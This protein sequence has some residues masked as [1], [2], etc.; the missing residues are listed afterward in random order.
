VTNHNKAFLE[1]RQI[2][3]GKT[4]ILV[5]TPLI[6]FGII[7]CES[8][9]EAADIRYVTSTS[10]AI[11]FLRENGSCRQVLLDMTFGE[12]KILNLGREL[13]LINPSIGILIISKEDP[14]TDMDEIQP[15]KFL[16]KPLL[17][18]DI[19]AA[20]GLEPVKDDNIIEIEPFVYENSIQEDWL[21]NA[22][23]ATKYL[24]LLIEKSF[25]QEALLIQNQSLWS[26]AGQLTEDAVYELEGKINTSYT[27]G[28]KTDIIRYIKLETSQ[29]EFA[30]YATII[31]IGVI[32][33]LVFDP[34]VPLSIIRKRTVEFSDQLFSGGGNLPVRAK[35]I[36]DE[37]YNN[38]G[39]NSFS[40]RQQGNSFHKSDNDP[41]AI[42]MR[43]YSE[44]N[45]LEP[46]GT[47]RQFHNPND[48]KGYQGSIN[49]INIEELTPLSSFS[50][51]VPKVENPRYP[52]QPLDHQSSYFNEMMSDIPHNLSYSCLIIPRFPSH[53][54]TKEKGDLLSDW[55]KKI[56]ISFGWRLEEL[57]VQPEYVRW[58]TILPPSVAPTNYLDTIRRE[59]SK[60]IFSYFPPFKEENPSGDYWAPGSLIIE[61]RNMISDQLA[62]AF[63]KQN[64]QKY[65]LEI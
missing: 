16:R 22:V 24:N 56:N 61:G 35:S 12:L 34:D 25:A 44:N 49:N 42:G 6:E 20:L 46:M 62:L 23:L 3:K 15:W 65:G 63:T 10:K 18:R 54:L 39:M 53:R 58:T 41:V 11:N 9:K 26:F 52:P 27:G 1:N 19:Q 51:R 5:V 33:A 45:S 57:E 47:A 2:V 50:G 37:K 48:Q 64:R 17:L 13:R 36:G 38:M 60:R 43:N 55:L 29:T 30:L 31:A 7:L 21:N 14:P 28:I 59:T 40:S 8:L 4:S 32:L